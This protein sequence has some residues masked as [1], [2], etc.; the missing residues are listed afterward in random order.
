LSFGSLTSGATN[1]NA[2]DDPITVNNTGNYNSTIDVT[3]LDL[4][5]ET[6]STDKIRADNFT[7]SF[8]DAQECTNGTTMLNASAITVAYSLSNKGNLTAGG[9]S[10]QETLYFCM[11]TVPLVP[12]Q[13][14]STTAG[15]AW[16]I[17]Y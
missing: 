6:D 10:G 16:T 9:G 17:A 5:G 13:T 14:Y 15:G 3:A 1:Q 11:P 2:T 7:I 12:T 8:I 4:L